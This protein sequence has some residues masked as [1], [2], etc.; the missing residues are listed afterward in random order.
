MI[1]QYL[2]D[3]ILVGFLHCFASQCVQLN[4][5]HSVFG[6]EMSEVRRMGHPDHGNEAIRLHA[7]EI[8]LSAS[9]NEEVV[10][11]TTINKSCRSSTEHESN[12]FGMFPHRLL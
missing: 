12:W 2:G 10:T 4:A 11:E 1:E 7:R 6:P 9:V 3:V 8:Q 5:K